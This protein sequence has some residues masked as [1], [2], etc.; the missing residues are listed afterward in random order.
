MKYITCVC[1]A[2][3]ET[4]HMQG[5]HPADGKATSCPTCRAKDHRDDDEDYL[6]PEPPDESL[7][8]MLV[9]VDLSKQELVELV[10]LHGLLMAGMGWAPAMRAAA[11]IGVQLPRTRKEVEEKEEKNRE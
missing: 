1:G 9:G 11:S 10:A 5:P 2:V 7:M 3:M 4:I 6:L 8:E